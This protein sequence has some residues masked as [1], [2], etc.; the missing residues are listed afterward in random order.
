MNM[1]VDGEWRTDTYQATNEEG[2]FERGQTT[3]RNWI[4]ESDVPDHVDAEPDDR[5]EAEAGRYH[6][7]V[8][9]ACPWAHRT[10]LVRALMG[11]E[12][13]IDV[14]VVDPYRGEDGWQ[15]TPE[16]AG[17]TEDKLHGSDYLREL[18]VEADPDATCRVTVPVLWDTK[19]AT[20]VNNESRE[21]IRM[22]S[23][24]FGDVGERDVDLAPESIREAV[25]EI[26]TAIYEPINNGVYRTGFATKQGPYDEAVEELFDAL[27]HWDEVLAEQRFLAGDQLTEADICLF[28]TLIRFD[29][30][31]HTHFMCNVQ[32]I[33]QYDNLWPYLRDV[34][35]QP[36]VAE[37]VDIDHIKEHYYTTHPDVTPH[38]IIAKG[39]DLDFSAPH[40]RDE[41]ASVA[42]DLQ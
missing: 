35:Q 14:S 39:P 32:Y 19:E 25:D 12:D 41:L 10:L 34:Y 1:L 26:I 11:L 9:Y 8:S 6:L 13:A 5:F 3:F 15:F 4:A 31:Y 22:L 33:H 29:H 37:T 21:I 24:G 28:T 38:G 42:A 20:I 30:V 17:C 7:Y 2:A 23:T 18:Y 27:D 40:D 16:K 36:G